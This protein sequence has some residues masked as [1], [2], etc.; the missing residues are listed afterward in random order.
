MLS[1]RTMIAAAKRIDSPEQNNFLKLLLSVQA[2]FE[3]WHFRLQY[4]IG[5]LLCCQQ[6][7]IQN[8]CEEMRT[9]F[10]ALGRH[11]L[12]SLIFDDHFLV[13]RLYACATSPIDDVCP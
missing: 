11:G 5:N 6:A 13:T 8:W 1:R 10:Y 12:V 9:V 3:K 2:I 4:F 7:P